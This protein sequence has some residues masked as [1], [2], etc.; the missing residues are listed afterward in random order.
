MQPIISLVTGAA[1]FVGSH[2]TDR[3]LALD[4]QVI[5]VDNLLLGRRSNLHQAFAHPRFSF[6]EADVNDWEAWRPRLQATTGSSSAQ[7]VWHLAANSDIRAGTADPEVDVRHTFL[8][9]YSVLKLM[10]AVGM[11]H[12]AFASS[13]AI[14]GPHQETLAEDSGPMLPISNYGAMKLA[15]EAMISAA[16]ETFLDKA[17]I[18][19]FPNV[20]GSRATHG[21]IHDFFQGL[22]ASPRELRVLGDGHQ[23]KP[24]LHVSELV[25][26]ML[27]I[28]QRATDR[29]NYYHIGVQD[30]ATTVRYIAEAVTR[31][32]A[33]GVSLRYLGGAQGWPGDVPR[34]RYSIDK[35]RRLGW[36]PR[37]TSNQAVDL[38][39]EELAKELA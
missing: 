30:S 36:S 39:I 37:L 38:A 27:F 26:A 28:Y 25:E 31:V 1:G 3:L 33:P 18:F 24:Y 20:V 15:S 16:L 10:K 22:R 8:T 11:R 7:V 19:R 35:L 9:T 13:S 32:A 5:G 21:V 4:H 6:I 14:Y 2:L 23:E 17:W 29:L 12:L 34:F